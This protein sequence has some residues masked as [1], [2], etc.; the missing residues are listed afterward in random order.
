MTFH[1][2]RNSL[3]FQILNNSKNTIK[4]KSSRYLGTFI[5]NVSMKKFPELQKFGFRSKDIKGTVHL[6]E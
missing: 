3:Q 2:L 5:L 6:F 1:F 4:I